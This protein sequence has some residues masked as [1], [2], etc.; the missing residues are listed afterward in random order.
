MPPDT[1]SSDDA[2]PVPPVWSR[3][4]TLEPGADLWVFGYGSL[5]W[6]PGFPFIAQ[7]RAVLYGYH[8]RFCIASHRYRGTPEHPGLVLGLDVGGC[9]HGI[10]F[11]VAA[12]HVPD[13][14]DY[15]WEREMFTRAY[16]PRMLGIRLD[17]GQGRRVTACAFVVDR[18]HGQY[19]GCLDDA[20][21]ARRI[22]GSVGER[23]PNVDYLANT[24]EHLEQLGL[25]DRRLSRLLAEVRRLTGEIRS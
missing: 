19:C 13:V 6:N 14:M 25:R 11:Q 18:Q 1:L 22:A 3:D 5:M 7:S 23:G 2:A 10:A 17:R 20:A 24:V 8:R 12:G 16:R 9:C 21:M 4:V 15:L